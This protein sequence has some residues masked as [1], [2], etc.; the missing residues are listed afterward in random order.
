MQAGKISFKFV[1]Q[2]SIICAADWNAF[3]QNFS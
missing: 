1:S 3:C 2:K